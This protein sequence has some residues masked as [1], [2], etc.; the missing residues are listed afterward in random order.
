MLASKLVCF[1]LVSHDDGGVNNDGVDVVDGI[2]AR[3]LVLCDAPSHS[4]SYWPAHAI[5]ALFGS[6]EVA[7]SVYA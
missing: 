1:F 6:H 7:S 5:D 4:L 3:A 2:C